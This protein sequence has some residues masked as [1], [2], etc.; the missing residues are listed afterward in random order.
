MTLFFFLVS[1]YLNV[2][3]ELWRVSSL[4]RQ[5]FTSEIKNGVF[6]LK[7]RQMFSVHITPDLCLRKILAVKSRD[8]RDVIVFAKLRFQNVSRPHENENPAFL[9]SSCFEERFRKAS[10][11]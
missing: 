8:Y 5:H 1:L 3:N 11:S 2:A 6:Y 4:V 7:A 9:N 10:F